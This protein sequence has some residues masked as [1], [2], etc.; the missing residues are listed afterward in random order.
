M[1]KNKAGQRNRKMMGESRWKFAA[2]VMGVRKV[3]TEK[4]E[5]D[6]QNQKHPKKMREEAM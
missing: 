3:I 4:M 1:E 6:E 2:L 5:F